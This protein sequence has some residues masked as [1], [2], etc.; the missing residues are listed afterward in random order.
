MFYEE[1]FKKTVDNN[2]DKKKNR[3][4]IV[5]QKKNSGNSSVSRQ[6]QSLNGLRKLTSLSMNS[7]HP[8]SVKDGKSL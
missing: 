5:S 1:V 2:L 6:K 3:S 7:F 8:K 4:A